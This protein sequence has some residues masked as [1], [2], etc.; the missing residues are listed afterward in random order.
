M[1]SETTEESSSSSSSSSSGDEKDRMSEISDSRSYS[2][3]PTSDLGRVQVLLAIH[4]SQTR[5]KNI[6]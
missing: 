1:T 4:F 3:E 6:N 5:R 2:A